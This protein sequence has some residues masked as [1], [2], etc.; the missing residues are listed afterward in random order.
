MR[1]QALLLASEDLCPLLERSGLIQE[2]RK[3]KEEVDYLLTPIT[4]IK[5]TYKD[6]VS[7]I[8]D[9]VRQEPDV[10]SLHHEATPINQNTSPGIW[11]NSTVLLQNTV[12]SSI[13][14]SCPS[15]TNTTNVLSG[16]ISSN[17]MPLRASSSPHYHTV[18]CNS[19]T[20]MVDRMI[21]SSCS[22]SK[23]QIPY[24]VKPSPSH[25]TMSPQQHNQVPRE[26]VHPPSA[27]LVS[28]EELNSAITN[29]FQN[30]QDMF[31]RFHAQTREEIAMLRSTELRHQP[32]LRH[33]PTLLQDAQHTNYSLGGNR[34]SRPLCRSGSPSPREQSPTLSNVPENLITTRLHQEKMLQ[35]LIKASE[36][37]F[38]GKDSQ[39]YAPWKR[40]LQKDMES[41]NLTSNQELS[42]LEAR[43]ED[44]AKMVIK[45]LRP[46]RNELG[47]DIALQRIWE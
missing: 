2:A 19:A 44:E 29:M 35:N 10:E 22:T 40:A 47:P 32:D 18:V 12:C 4:N 31:T 13:S 34:A 9:S 17:I 43:T 8:T 1:E 27:R 38:D 33:P 25:L 20:C 30:M 41:L 39:E 36:A 42:L 3:V 26:Y 16:G 5:L 46:L 11:N 6:L 21:T 24:V 45:E 28:Q 14:N 15:N 23:G 7:N 37:K